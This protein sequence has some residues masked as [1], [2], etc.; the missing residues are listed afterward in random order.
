MVQEIEASPE[1]IKIP[2]KHFGITLRQFTIGDAEYIL[3]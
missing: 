1:P 3:T 2:A